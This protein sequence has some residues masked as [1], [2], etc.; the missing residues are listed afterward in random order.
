MEVNSNQVI[1]SISLDLKDIKESLS[2]FSSIVKSLKNGSISKT[3]F[4]QF[5]DWIQQKEFQLT[6]Y[7]DELN[8]SYL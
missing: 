3:Q 8:S 1:L 6:H 4:I 7:I 5:N 2:K